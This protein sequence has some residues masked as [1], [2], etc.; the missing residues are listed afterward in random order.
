M[1]IEPLGVPN[2]F[3]EQ[4]S[5]VGFE[6]RGVSDQDQRLLKAGSQRAVT[7]S[8]EH[9]VAPDVKFALNDHQKIALALYSIGKVAGRGKPTLTNPDGIGKDKGGAVTEP[10]INDDVER[11]C[12][13]IAK[14]LD[15]QVKNYHFRILKSAAWKGIFPQDD[16]PKVNWRKIAEQIIRSDDLKEQDGS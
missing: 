10:D 5:V 12:I 3:R 14:H 6:R 15:A 11:H 9:Q 7:Y 13:E 1:V 16:L 8:R 4:H 2:E